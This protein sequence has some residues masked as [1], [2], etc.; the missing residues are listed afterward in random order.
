MV[1]D[2]VRRLGHATLGSRLK[3]IG[4]RLQADTQEL[5]ARLAESDLPVAHNPVLA[6][7]DRNGPMSIG[8]LAQALGQSQPGITRMVG[9]M[10]AA[11]LVE[12]RTDATDRRVSTVRLTTRGEALT[13]HLK[14]V[15]WPAVEAAVA[16]ACEGLSGTLLEQLDQLED[17]LAEK[18]LG[19]RVRIRVKA[20]QAGERKR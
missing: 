4:E 20:R 11:G 9:K 3:R 1:E 8:D 13:T 17:R 15:L 2:V 5:T 14:E 6:A 19:R 7:L 12:T 16:D 10:K 18:P